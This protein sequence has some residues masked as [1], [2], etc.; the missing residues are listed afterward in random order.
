MSDG[1]ILIE[2]LSAVEVYST[3]R[4]EVDTVRRS[5]LQVI[6][7]LLEGDAASEVSRVGKFK[8]EPPPSSPMI[9][10]QTIV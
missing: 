6:W 1:K 4:K 5:H 7:R 10:R 3:Y 8:F 2:H 9:W